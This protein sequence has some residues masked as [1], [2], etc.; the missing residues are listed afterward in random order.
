MKNKT[1]Q[2]QNIVYSLFYILNRTLVK[3]D[4]KLYRHSAHCPSAI[5]WFLDE[6]PD[7]WP[8]VPQKMTEAEEQEEDK[9]LV[10]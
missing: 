1:K 9:D 6:N 3:N 8:F 10:S 4:M 7:Y 5:Q 2:K